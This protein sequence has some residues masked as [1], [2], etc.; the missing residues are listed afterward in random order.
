MSTLVFDPLNT[1]LRYLHWI[2]SN[3]WTS[4]SPQISELYIKIGLMSVLKR[5]SRM[6]TLVT[7]NDT[8]LVW[9]LHRDLFAFLLIWDKH[10][11][12]SQ[13]QHSQVPKYLYLF[14]ISRDFEPISH[15][16]VMNVDF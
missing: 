12:K 1:N 6:L 10:S 13:F 4:S 15:E 2:F 3:W 8:T 5:V 7:P 16:S 9:R 14:T 11:L